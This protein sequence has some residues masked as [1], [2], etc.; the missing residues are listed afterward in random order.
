MKK[1]YVIPE[2]IDNTVRLDT[3]CDEV[4]H[5]GS[6]TDDFTKERTDDSEEDEALRENLDNS[7]NYSLW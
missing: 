7:I 4:I 2:V 6:P 3:F 1:L 5:Q